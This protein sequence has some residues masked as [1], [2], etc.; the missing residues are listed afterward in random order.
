MS[1][2]L[3]KYFVNGYRYVPLN[4][5]EPVPSIDLWAISPNGL[6]QTTATDKPEHLRYLNFTRISNPTVRQAAKQWFWSEAKAGFENRCRNALYIMEFFEYR[7]TLRSMYLDK[8]V[9]VRSETDLD[10]ANTVLTEEVVMVQAQTDAI[11]EIRNNKISINRVAK[12]S[13]IARQTFYNNPIITAY[14]EA[15]IAANTSASPYETIETLREE[16]RRKDEQIA[17]LV[18]RDATVSKCKT[19]N[20]ELT[21]EIA[22]L[23][24]TIKSQEELIR[25][26][27]GNPN[28]LQTKRR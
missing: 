5:N 23:R 15:Y 6:E 24:E 26:L 17:G 21:D 28:V 10:T 27:R 9:Q 12:E 19:E 16:I 18:Q 7:E 14:I 1:E 4:P 13:G 22:S 2:G 11:Q 25:Q 8:F 20:L 3:A